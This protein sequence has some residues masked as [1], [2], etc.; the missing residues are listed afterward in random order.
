MIDMRIML[1]MCNT[2]YTY[3]CVVFLREESK[4]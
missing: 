3:F 2:V 1:I 4:Q